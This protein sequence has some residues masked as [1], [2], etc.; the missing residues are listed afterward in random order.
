MMKSQIKILY[1]ILEDIQNEKENLNKRTNK[2]TK[3]ENK[4]AA[5][6]CAIFE[7]ENR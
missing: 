5:L 7:L 3:L 1:E 2:Y 4:E 6:R